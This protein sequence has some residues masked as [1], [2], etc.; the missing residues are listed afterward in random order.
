MVFPIADYDELLV[1]EVVPL[2]ARLSVDRTARSPRLGRRPARPRA[3]VL[4]RIDTE[5]EGRSVP[6]ATTVVEAVEVDDVDEP[7]MAHS[8]RRVVGR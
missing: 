3:S 6:A 2:L 8:G 1:T 7:T 5:I 4:R